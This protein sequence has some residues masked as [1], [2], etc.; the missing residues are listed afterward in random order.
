[1]HEH[2]IKQLKNLQTIEPDNGFVSRTRNIFT[3]NTISIATPSRSFSFF[4]WQYASAFALVLL[5]VLAVP[6]FAFTPE[7]TLASLDTE[8]LASEIQSLPI[9]VELKELNYNQKAQETITNAVSEVSNTDTNHLNESLIRKEEEI[10][11]AEE[12]VDSSVDDLLNEVIR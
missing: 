6:F 5:C 7:E 10:I 4:N 12:K 2:I 8:S 1:M 9:N 11:K 3:P